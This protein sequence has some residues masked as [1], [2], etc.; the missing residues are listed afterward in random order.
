[1]RIK[2]H[3]RFSVVFC[4][5]TDNPQLHHKISLLGGTN[6][7]LVPQAGRE[8]R[9]YRFLLIDESCGSERCV[10]V[11]GAAGG[12]GERRP[13]EGPDADGADPAD[14]GGDPD[15]GE[16]RGARQVQGARPAVV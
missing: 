8:N 1:M 13:G 7:F 9:R 6:L 10:F 11:A 3:C 4:R 15:G 2:C 16:Q 14:H 12:A 5:I